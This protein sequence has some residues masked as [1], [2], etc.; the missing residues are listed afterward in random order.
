MTNERA[1]QN[2]ITELFEQWANEPC[3]EV[4][5]IG[6][7]GSKRRYF[8]LKGLKHNC[9]AA[10]N[11]DRRENDAFLYY[12]AFFKQKNLPVPE[13]YAVGN[14]HLTYLQQDLG[15]QTLFNYIYDKKRS[16][17]GFDVE[18]INLYRRVI[19]DLIRFQTE[20]RD[21][22]FD[23]AY[24]RSA[25]DEQSIQWDLNYFKYYFLKPAEIPF[26]EQLIED[27][28]KNFLNYL[29][30]ADTS[31][32]M[33][34]DFQPRNIMLTA[35]GEL[36]YIDYQGGRRGAA[37]YDLASLLFSARSD[38]PDPIRRELLTY[39]MSQRGFDKGQRQQ[40]ESYYWAYVLVRIMQAMGAYGYR[41]YFEHKD[42]FVKS[43][44]LA[45][46][47]LRKVTE[48]VTLP[49]ELP[50]L[51]QVWQ[52]IANK[53]QVFGQEA[54]PQASECLTV[55]VSSFSYKRGIPNDPSGNGGGFVFDCRAL[56]NP[57]R[58]EQYRA[59]TGK[60]KPVIDFL[61]KE[62][63]VARFLN[64]A[65][66]LVAQSSEKYLERHFT[67]LAVNFVCTGGQHRSVYCSEKIAQFIQQ[68]YDC[69]VIIKHIEQEL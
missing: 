21:I 16:G 18:A 15:D 47:N 46:S 12:S 52:A 11:D 54:A 6:A 60:D 36:Y 56:P 23:K 39:Y 41:G 3:T 7:H 65:K 20:C 8:R 33:Y 34:R 50:H 38:M 10:F 28:F 53:Q 9:I 67:S 68:N 19:E 45:I 69:N 62:E 31:Y 5:A 40:F 24:P 63:P 43:L 32:F 42:H 66:N 49:V 1:I 55:R 17:G 30:S 58:Y 61:E 27:D 4:L 2:S 13:I 44:P 26:D 14:D 22:D 37:Q 48:S 51:S 64:N 57:G 25:F 29:L 35:T 59:Y